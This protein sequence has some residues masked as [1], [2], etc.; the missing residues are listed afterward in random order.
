MHLDAIAR[1]LYAGSR[2]AFTATRDARVRELRAAGETQLARE[3]AALRKPTVAAAVVNLLAR[4]QPQQV[5]ALLQLGDEMRRAQQ[6][7]DGETL[8]RLVEQQ[9]RDVASL[10]QLALGLA[11]KRGLAVNDSVAASVESTLRAAVADPQ[12]GAGVAAGVLAREQQM[13][14]FPVPEGQ[15]VP[16]PQPEP[17]PDET[18][19]A[20]AEQT[21]DEAR[22]GLTA[23]EQQRDQAERDLDEVRLRHA[24]AVE[25][26]RQARAALQQAEARLREVRR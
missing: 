2:E 23:A 17:E 24:H 20:A 22:A 9:R 12:V 3:V 26:L 8:R 7:R 16:E 18:A 1:E 15:P 25:V 21:L 11:T 14:G 5:T 13:S 4:E 6:Q 10:V 19:I